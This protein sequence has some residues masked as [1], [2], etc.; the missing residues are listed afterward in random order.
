MGHGRLSPAGCS[1]QPS[2][3]RD[4]LQ[5]VPCSP[6]ADIG[7][8]RIIS[9]MTRSDCSGSTPPGRRAEPSQV[10]R[11]RRSRPAGSPLSQ[12]AHPAHEWSFEAMLS[13]C[14]T[15]ERIRIGSRARS[16]RVPN[17]RCAERAAFQLPPPDEGFAAG[18]RSGREFG[19][20]PP[21]SRFQ[22]TIR[23]RS[24]DA[25]IPGRPGRSA[26]RSHALPARG[27]LSDEPAAVAGLLDDDRFRAPFVARFNRAIGRPAIPIETNHERDTSPFE[28]DEPGVR[29]GTAW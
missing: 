1:L 28:I 2:R 14:S 5:A 22:L 20:P 18:G 10:A 9:A 25:P 27:V 29:T 15:H 3:K 17:D 26:G 19:H 8:V 4:G 11:Q 21:S 12:S 16:N 7:S 13:T 23:R 6:P 24:R